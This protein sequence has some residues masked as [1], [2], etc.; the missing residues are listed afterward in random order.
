MPAGK[1][2]FFSAVNSFVSPDATT[3]GRTVKS[4]TTLTLPPCSCWNTT[5][6]LSGTSGS[7]AA[8][9][10]EYFILKCSPF[11]KGVVA[12]RRFTVYLVVTLVDNTIF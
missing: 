9:L 12:A 11:F 10:T 7:P 3:A 5:I 2:I 8:T 1:S 4:S 6:K